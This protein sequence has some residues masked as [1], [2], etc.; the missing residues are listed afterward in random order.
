M[1]NLSAVILAGG[2]GQRMGGRDKGLVEFRDR[3]MIGHTV[4]LVRPHVDSLII[5]CNRNEPR[6]QTLADKTVVDP[7]DDFQGPLAGILAGLSVCE[8]EL[9]LVLPCDTPLLSDELL[10]R[11][12][13]AAA[14]KPDYITVLAE[15]DEWHPL[16]SVI[17]AKHSADLERWLEGGQRA[18]QRW[19]RTHPFQLVDISDLS[20]QLYN[21]NTPQELTDRE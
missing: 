7:L 10:A 18:V 19:M 17:P 13:A 12:F 9:L 11:L 3:P 21:L 6:Y 16:H 4:E 1:N 15:G 14:D 8:T 2:Q 5:S 20:E